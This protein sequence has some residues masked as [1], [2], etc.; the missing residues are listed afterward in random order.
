MSRLMTVCST[1]AKKTVEQFRSFVS[2]IVTT[3]VADRRRT[4]TE[5]CDSFLRYSSLKLTSAAAAA[6]LPSGSLA[7]LKMKRYD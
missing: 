4:R 2:Y 6:A 3:S 5:H 1:A 7:R